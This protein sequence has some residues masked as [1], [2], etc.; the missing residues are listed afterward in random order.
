MAAGEGRERDWWRA[1][2]ALREAEALADLKAISGPA[3]GPPAPGDEPSWVDDWAKRAREALRKARD[4]S[5]SAKRAAKD[6]ARAIADNVRRGV[7]A[8]YRASPGSQ[9][10]A[11]L[12]ALA[13][14][15][16]TITLAT[17]IGTGVLTLGL[18]WLGWESL[19]ARRGA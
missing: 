17:A 9:A 7:R 2:S 18:L 14:A 6:R 4:F 16:N 12:R 5:E 8:I 1:V 11:A 19:K 10:S 3:D 15:A 13:E